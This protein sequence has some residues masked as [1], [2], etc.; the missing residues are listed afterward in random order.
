LFLFCGRRAD[1][2]KGLLWQ[3]DG[4]LLLYKRLDDGHFRWPRDKNEV[5]ELS[6]QQLRW[7]LEGLSPEQKTT[8]KRR[9]NSAENALNKAIS[10]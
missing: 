7:L 8:V 3:Q 1:R 4:F 5:R 9:Y 2:I 6:P 10:V